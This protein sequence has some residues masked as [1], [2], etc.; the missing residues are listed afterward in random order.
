MS[1]S[2][3]S[4]ADDKS[5]SASSACSPESIMPM[6]SEQTFTRAVSVEWPF[7]YA[8]WELNSFTRRNVNAWNSLLFPTLS[9]SCVDHSSFKKLVLSF[10][11]LIVIRFGSVRIRV[12]DLYHRL[13]PIL[14]AFG[15]RFN[16]C[17][18]ILIK[19]FL[20]VLFEIETRSSRSI[21][22]VSIYHLSLDPDILML[23]VLK[24]S[25]EKYSFVVFFL[26]YWS[27]IYFI[28]FLNARTNSPYNLFGKDNNN[29]ITYWMDHWISFITVSLSGAV[30]SR[31]G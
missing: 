28:H 15:F 27:R 3:V 29:I 31:S 20:F 30:F 24:G 5:R 16:F 8:D 13:I 25:S 22:S 2:T 21:I 1:W 19:H 14:C 17:F 4:K 9:V 23:P 11:L 18:A 6:K 10:C 12:C 7:L 26:W